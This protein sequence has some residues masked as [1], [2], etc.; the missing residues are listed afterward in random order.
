MGMSVPHAAE[1]EE[2]TRRHRTL[3]AG[4]RS[5]GCAAP[6]DRG[7]DRYRGN[8]GHGY[9]IAGHLCEYLRA[10]SYYKYVD[11]LRSLVA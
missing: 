2:G 4:P 8:G 9:L 7:W 5:D 6:L 3:P 11:K 1:T 10:D